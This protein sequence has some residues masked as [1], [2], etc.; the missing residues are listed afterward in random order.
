VTAPETSKV[1]TFGET[2]V[3]M[4]S[5]EPGPIAHAGSLRLGI[6]G[7]ESNVAIGLARAGVAVTWAGRTGDDSFGE[8]VSREIRAE[9]VRV[10]VTVDQSAP[11]GLMVKERRTVEQTRVQYYRDR[12]AGSRL[13]A[14]DLPHELI[15]DA[16][17]LHM[18]GITPALSDTA[19]EAAWSAVQTAKA[20][21][22]LISFDVNY[23]SGLWSPERA[24]ESLVPF[25]NESDLV[26]AGQHEAAVVVGDR[27]SEEALL[28]AL[29]G[30]GRRTAVLKLGALGAAATA[31]GQTFRCAANPVQPLDTVGAGDAFVAGYLAAILS[32]D[33]IHDALRRGNAHGAYACLAAGDWEGAPRNDEWKTFEQY[34]LD[35][36]TR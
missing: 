26:F 31:N 29:S 36:V 14:Q 5:Q 1:V 4:R 18:S 32:G 7:A 27:P 13:E 30:E 12:S 9:G 11:T 2:M 3:L 28:D 20:A 6:G 17:I 16:E 21:G 15:R 25:I 24:A 23:R 35:P 33:G 34:G 19:R 8:L 10:H 22:T